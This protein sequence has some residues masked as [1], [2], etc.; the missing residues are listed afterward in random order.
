MR[1]FKGNTSGSILSTRLNIPSKII[2]YTLT[3][4]SAAGATVIVAI[5]SAGNQVYVN[6]VVIATD[7]Q[8][9]TDLNIVVPAGSEIL[10]TTTASIDYYFSIE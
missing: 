4:K 7:A 5:V 9:Q 1:A 3:D 6:R 2:S 8:Y 10:V